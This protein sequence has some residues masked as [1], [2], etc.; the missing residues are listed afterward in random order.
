VDLQ[1]RDE[2]AASQQTAE[3]RAGSFPAWMSGASAA[4]TSGGGLGLP[5]SQE[6]QWTALIRMP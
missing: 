4:A 5:S 6:E 3:K 1:S 2:Q